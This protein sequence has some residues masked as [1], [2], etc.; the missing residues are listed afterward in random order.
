MLK[1]E[2]DTEDT[3]PPQLSPLTGS[4]KLASPKSGT[5][6]DSN[7]YTRTDAAREGKAGSTTKIKDKICEK[8]EKI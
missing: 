2:R 1:G 3:R 6:T 5:E 8:K 4:Q 7:K